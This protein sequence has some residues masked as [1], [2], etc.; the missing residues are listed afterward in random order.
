MQQP[1]FTAAS[2]AG[3]NP[4]HAIQ[5]LSAPTSA[6]TAPALSRAMLSD[7]EEQ[8]ELDRLLEDDGFGGP[9]GVAEKFLPAAQQPDAATINSAGL[10]ARVAAI[11]QEVQAHPTFVRA[12]DDCDAA[13]DCPP[14]L[15]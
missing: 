11:L 1:G 15:Q 10:A 5:S 14:F 2:A 4:K 8:A 3:N 13:Y 9:S 6:R 12:L 7:D